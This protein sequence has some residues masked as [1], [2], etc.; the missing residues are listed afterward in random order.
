MP[1]V[2]NRQWATDTMIFI[3]AA[4]LVFGLLEIRQHVVKAPS[5][6]AM[7][8]PT[9]IIRVLAANVKQAVD[10]ARSAQHLA[11]RLKYGSPVQSRLRFRLVH[12]VDGFFLEQLA[13]THRHVDPEIGI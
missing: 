5:S 8:A 13:V 11:A 2:R 1:Q 4:L 9:I 6:V 7:L 3:T 12:P 10:G